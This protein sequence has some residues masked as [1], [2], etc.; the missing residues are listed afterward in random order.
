MEG[1]NIYNDVG[2]VSSDD[3][4]EIL[5]AEDE[6]IVDHASAG[7]GAHLPIPT[8]ESGTG[9]L[10]PADEDRHVGP[11]LYHQHQ[12]G[13]PTQS[14]LKC[15]SVRFEGQSCT[16]TST[17]REDCHLPVSG[18]ILAFPDHM[19]LEARRRFAKFLILGIDKVNEQRIER[20]S[21]GV[22]G[23]ACC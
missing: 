7:D 23:W 5:V 17:E 3:D 4:F 1:L 18:H 21:L 15:K 16:E 20:T 11:A 14:K 10:P 8:S 6:N 13:G 19:L 12:Q 9:L 2:G 22:E